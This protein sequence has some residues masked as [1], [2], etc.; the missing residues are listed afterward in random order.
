[1]SSNYL[2]DHKLAHQDA[3]DGVGPVGREDEAINQ[4]LGK[5]IKAMRI[6]GELT[7]ADLS[8]RSGVSRAMLSKVERGEKSPTLPLVV[9]I[10]KGLAMP[11]SQLIGEVPKPSLVTV[12]RSH[13]RLSFRDPETGFERWVLS[14][15]HINNGIELILHRIPPGQSSG[16]LPPYNSPVTK[17]ITVSEGELTVYVQDR[18]Y[19]LKTGDTMHFE[20][21]SSYRLVNH[22]WTR[23]CAY[24]MVIAQHPPTR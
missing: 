9:R 4:S 1:M 13:E 22:D 18:P 19:T 6:A 3:P 24:Y 11:L 10:A 21:D 17:Y 14:P 5:R 15:D 23:P 8:V 16:N 20:V 7:L 12:I 2:P